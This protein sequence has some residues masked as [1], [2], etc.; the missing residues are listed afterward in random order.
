MLT[1]EELRELLN[2]DEAYRIERT[3]SISNTDKFCQAIC[4]FS[5]DMPNSGKKGYLLIGVKDNGTLCGLK[6]TDELNKNISAI[7]SDGN[8][9]PLPIMSVEAFSFDEGDVLVVEVTPSMLMPVRYRGRTYIRVGARKDFATIE[10]ERVLSERASKF[11]A[12]FDSYPCRNATI[13][14]IDTKL[15]VNDYLPL[16]IDDEVLINDTRSVKE[17]MSALHLYDL[18][19]DCPTYAAIILF[20]KN[21]TYFLFGNYI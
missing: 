18:Q 7:R 19:H 21:P 14:D 4:A 20:G 5:N 1:K 15:F 12:T 10:E 13:N 2:C 11:Y 3:T 8:I 16:A 9:L 17:Q 6:A